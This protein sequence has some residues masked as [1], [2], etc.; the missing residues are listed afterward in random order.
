M[1]YKDCNGISLKVGD[2]IKRVSGGSHGEI[3][4]GDIGIVEKL[5]DNSYEGILLKGHL[6]VKF[7]SSYF[8]LVKHKKDHLPDWM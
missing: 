7:K 6:H 2:R 4:E 5:C 1:N 3:E 8:E